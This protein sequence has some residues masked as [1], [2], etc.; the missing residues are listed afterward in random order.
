MVLY[1]SFPNFPYP[2]ILFLIRV[3]TLKG[4]ILIISTCT[5]SLNLVISLN[6]P[7]SSMILM[8]YYLSWFFCLTVIFNFHVGVVSL[9]E[10]VLL[11]INRNIDY[12]CYHRLTVLHLAVVDQ[13]SW[14]SR[15]HVGILNGPL[16]WPTSMGQCVCVCGNDRECLLWSH[17]S[18][19]PSGSRRKNIMKPSVDTNILRIDITESV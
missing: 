5:V 1:F 12:W 2:Y 7:L 3:A 14:Y 18:L 16:R 8:F 17:I 15:V 11:L 4:H 10:E 6:L 19:S 9:Y 13:R